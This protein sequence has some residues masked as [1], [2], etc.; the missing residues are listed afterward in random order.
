MAKPISQFSMPLVSQKQSKPTLLNKTRSYNHQFNCLLTWNTINRVSHCL[1]ANST[2]KLHK[3]SKTHQTLK[4]PHPPGIWPGYPKCIPDDSP[5]SVQQH[6][7]HLDTNL[8]QFDGDT[9]LWKTGISPDTETQQIQ[10][11][12]RGMLF[13]TTPS[14]WNL[15]RLPQMHTRW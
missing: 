9:E 12:A 7:T 15:C 5:V 6:D 14:S 10:S 4:H 2:K 8:P 11:L 3:S 1:H 13:R